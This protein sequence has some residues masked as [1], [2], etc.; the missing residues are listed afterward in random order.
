[1]T[2]SSSAKAKGQH[3]RICS[4]RSYSH[5]AMIRPA[6]SSDARRSTAGVVE[7]SSKTA[8]NVAVAKDPKTGGLVAADAYHGAANGTPVDVDVAAT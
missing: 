5:A 3:P 1:M 7:V 6:P 4:A 2:S 8:C